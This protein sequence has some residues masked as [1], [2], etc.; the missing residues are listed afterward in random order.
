MIQQVPSMQV[1]AFQATMEL[2]AEQFPGAFA[3]YNLQVC[4]LF[5]DHSHQS[6]YV[7]YTGPN[8]DALCA[9]WDFTPR[10]HRLC[11]RDDWQGD[12]L[13]VVESHQRSKVDTS[14]TAKAIIGSF[15]KLG[16]DFNEV[17]CH[18]NLLHIPAL[19]PPLTSLPGAASRVLGRLLFVES[20]LHQQDVRVLN[21]TEK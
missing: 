14:G 18:L 3:G 2:M 4:Y 6:E 19:D 1:V 11:H 20:G 9:D 13:Q 8:F 17:T 7:R 5:S 15:Q 12:A 21:Y 16:V 10:R